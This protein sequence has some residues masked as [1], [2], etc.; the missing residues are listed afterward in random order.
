MHKVYTGWP[1]L[2]KL[3]NNVPFLHRAA[4][5]YVYLSRGAAIQSPPRFNSGH[6]Y[7][8]TESHFNTSYYAR[9]LPPVPQHCPTPMGVAG[10]FRPSVHS[11][12]PNLFQYLFV[13]PTGHRELPDIDELAERFFKR[14]EFIAEPHGTN[15]LFAYYAQHFSHQFFRT[16]RARGPAFTKGNDGVDVSHIYGLD[17]GTQDALRSFQL[18]KMKVRIDADG[19]QFPPLL[20]DAPSVHMIYPPHTPEEE[21]VAL[22]HAL[23]S[24]QPGLFVMATVWL[25]EHNRLCDVLAVE[26]PDWDDERLYQ[27]AK[28]IVL[29]QNLKITIEEYVQ[30]LSQYKVK[31]SY[32]PELLRDE[33]QFQFSNRIHVEFAHLYHW[34]PMAPEAITLGNNTYT[35]E[36]MSFSTKT[37]AKHG[38][39]SFVQA[40]ATQPAGAVSFLF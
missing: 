38:F 29:A 20:R 6:D 3:V 35:L 4:M 19:Q 10:R 37:V 24:M 9:S 40:I 16:D 32:D 17:K 25:R 8:T 23:F 12:T 22:G 14:K 27:T 11:W 2:W 34:H 39:A 5:R 36:Q 13:A 31:L 1:W 30:H 28:L 15:I 18:G 26:H 33:P 7:I 21:K